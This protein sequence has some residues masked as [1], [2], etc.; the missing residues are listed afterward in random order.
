[1]AKLVKLD[2]DRLTRHEFEILKASVLQ[3]LD[4]YLSKRLPEYSRSL[5]QKL[6]KEGRVTVN[7]REVKPSY[8]I[9]LG[10]R[11]AVDVPKR[12]EPHVVPRDLPLD[13]VHEDEHLI[14]VNKPAGFVVHPAAGH[15]DDTLVNALLHHCGVLPESDEVY[16]PGIV[17]RL[18]KETSG[19]L[20]AAKTLAAHGSLTR[21]FQK[22]TVEK[23][24]YAI[25]EGEVEYDADVIEKSL[26]RH[27]HHFEKMAV[28]KEG[29]GKAAVSTYEVIERFRGFTY[30]R[31]LPKTGRTHQIRVHVAAIGHPCVADSTYGKRD[32][33]F[34]RDLTGEEGVPG[35]PL[36]CRQAL[37]AHRIRIEHPATGEPAEYRAPL[38]SDLEKTLEALRAYRKM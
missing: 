34:L 2:Y 11:I 19:I 38:A 10:D 17:H 31:V 1:M 33:L 18:D 22:R 15:W 5:M 7:G 36:V 27:K 13:I 28:V 24:Y 20:L 25:V 12:I 29:R 21:Q 23:E 30:L 35:E 4:V 37:H 26:D 6:V 14:A 9:Q 3:R 8:G 32:A 16:K